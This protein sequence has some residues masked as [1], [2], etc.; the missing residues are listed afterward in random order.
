MLSEHG[1][2]T[3]LVFSRTDTRWAQ[4][5]FKLASQVFFLKGRIKFLTAEFKES[6]NAG[7]GSM[8]LNYGDKINFNNFEG[9]LA[10]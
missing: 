10:K 8:F 3:A 7:H 1:N 2:G 4:R 6:T 9:W 5:H